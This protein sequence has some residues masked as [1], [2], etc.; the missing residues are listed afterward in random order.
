ML[1][2]VTKLREAKMWNA[3]ELY[4]GLLQETGH[5][6]IADLEEI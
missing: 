6:N 2:Q 1:N 3:L 4:S 5:K